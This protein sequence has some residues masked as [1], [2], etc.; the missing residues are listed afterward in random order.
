M[1]LLSCVNQAMAFQ[2]RP[3]SKGFVAYITNVGLL[4]IVDT[5]MFPQLGISM[6]AFLAQSTGKG[7]F[8]CV[9]YYMLIVMRF[10]SERFVA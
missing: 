6:K 5:R 3:A 4:F 9:G 10:L 1:F 7:P 8:S 2:M